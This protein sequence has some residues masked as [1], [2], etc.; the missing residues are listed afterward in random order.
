M[1]PFIEGICANLS[2]TMRHVCT[3]EV[4]VTSAEMTLPRERAVPIGMVVNELITNAFKHG[5]PMGGNGQVQVTLK[6]GGDVCLEVEDNGKGCPKETREGV[7]TLLV[8][9]LTKQL[10]GTIERTEAHPGCKVTLRVPP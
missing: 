8:G 6:G 7:G 2:D 5:F 3:V 4:D 10:G 9:Q 1:K